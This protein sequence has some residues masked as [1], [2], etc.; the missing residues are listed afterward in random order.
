[1]VD[2][3]RIRRDDKDLVERFLMMDEWRKRISGV[4][5]MLTDPEDALSRERGYLPVEGAQGSIMNPEV[6]GKTRDL[7]QATVKRLDDKFKFFVVDTSADPYKGN[8]GATCKDVA[9]K[10]L[11]WVDEQIEENIL[12]VD[13]SLVTDLFK[14]GGSL[15]PTDVIALEDVFV[16]TG[17]YRPRSL[18]ESDYDRIQA[19]PIVV[20]RNSSGH[21]LTL[22]R[23][24][25]KPDNKLHGK[26]VVWAGGHVRKED[27]SAGNPLKV[28]AVRELQ[29]ELRIRITPDDLSILGGIY[30]NDGAGSSKHVA[31]VYE[32]RAETDNVAVALNKSE[33]FERNGTS[34]SCNFVDR[35]LLSGDQDGAITEDWSREILDRLLMN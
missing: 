12:S 27:S 25:N 3:A 6:L 18:V 23:K 30:V 10:I 32:W 20:V 11:D 19:L 28:C 2:L 5:V 22:C 16:K 35:M 1:M 31:I 21:V 8:Q 29:E 13:K 15:G 7:V 17:D 26:M 14:N 34:V 4:I 33:F 24:E 9:I